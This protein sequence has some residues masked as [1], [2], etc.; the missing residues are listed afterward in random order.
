M[1]HKRAIES[2]T[3]GRRALLHI[4][5]PAGKVDPELILDASHASFVDAYTG[6]AILGTVGHHLRAPRRNHRA[7]IMVP[8]GGEA[9]GRFSTL[10]SAP[11]E[12]CTLE[13]PDGQ[14]A[15]VRDPRVLLP[16]L[17]IDSMEEA[18]ALALFLQAT[19]QRSQLGDVRLSTKEA[20]TLAEALPA[21]VDNGLR[22]G[23]G[24][25]CGV[26]ACSAFESDTREVQLVVLDLG[27]QAATSAD[28]LD[29]LREAWSHSRERLGGLFYATELARRRG[30]DISLQLKTG[31]AQARWRERF[32]SE[33]AEFSPGWAASITIHR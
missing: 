2:G 30:L 23:A 14:T 11:P 9:M 24:S 18:D 33:A 25:S 20:A 1:T 3:R 8:Q 27:R 17:R 31:G 12:R 15:P 32:H 5:A 10:L 4:H 26:I 22:H 7:R 21:L 29:H 16:A 13:L 6:V 28:P 19:A